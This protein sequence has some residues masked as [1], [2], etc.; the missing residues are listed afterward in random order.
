MTS[1]SHCPASAEPRSDVLVRRTHGSSGRRILL[2]D[3]NPGIHQDFRKVLGP[4]ANKAVTPSAAEA[5]LFGLARSGPTRPVFQ[6]DSALQGDEGVVLV[7]R[8]LQERRPYSLAFVD[9]RMPPGCDGIETIERLWRHDPDLQVVICTA[10]SDYSWDETRERLGHGDR[11]VILKK[12]FEVIEVLQLAEALTEK[13][14]LARQERCRIQ[15]LEQR[16]EE[17]NRDL[18][19]IQQSNPELHTQGRPIAGQTE[20]HVQRRHSLERD[21]RTPCK[22]VRLPCTT[23]R[24][25][26]SRAG[27]WSL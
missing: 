7:R 9:M 20:S 6:L 23:N 27:G 24:W 3:D 26:R 2:I 25:S 11:F 21:L 12:P 5:S 15:E 14:R 22:P 8:A 16:I 17:R 18:E 19:A 13:W 1:R 4:D 10:Y